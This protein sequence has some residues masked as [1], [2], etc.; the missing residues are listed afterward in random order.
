MDTGEQETGAKRSRIKQI[1]ESHYKKLLLIPLIMLLLALLQIGYQIASTG[2]FVDKG[3]TLKGGVSV[4]VSTEEGIDTAGLERELRAAM[5]QDDVSVRSLI[6]TGRGSGFIVEANIDIA[7]REKVDSLIGQIIKA[8]GMELSKDD[9]SVEGIGSSLG[10][11]FFR[12][13]LIAI[14][15]AFTFMGIVVFIY[16]R[17]F[18]PSMAV[19]L[20]AFSDM[21]VTLAVINL[22][23]VKLSTAG[24]A[25]FLML[26]GYSVDTDILLSTKVLRR[27]QGTL[28]E[29][30]YSAMRTGLTMN[31]STMAAVAIAMAVSDSE[32]IRQIM[33]IIFIGLVADIIN[34][35]IQNAGI[36]M[37]YTERKKK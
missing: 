22:L 8:S 4:F 26:I 14:I 32:V 36:L 10:Q 13:A 31:L 3:I 29:R 25:A 33:L 19:I 37:W 20:A 15:V 24:I 6:T 7:D 11:S 1:Y 2:D 28:I 18:I 17:T 21:V 5:P 23:G 34:T 9:Y 27:R 12:E 30:V 16:F 35:W